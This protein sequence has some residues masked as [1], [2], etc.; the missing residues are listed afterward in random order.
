MDAYE[1]CVSCIT[2]DGCAWS[3]FEVEGRD[4]GNCLL[5]DVVDVLSEPLNAAGDVVGGGGGRCQS[6]DGQMGV[7]AFAPDEGEV[8][9]VASNGFCGSVGQ[10]DLVFKVE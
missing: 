10:M 8:A 2:R 3:L 4:K 9:Y 7:Y 1:C 6:Q 5:Y